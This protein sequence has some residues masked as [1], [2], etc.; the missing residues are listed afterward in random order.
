M[1]VYSSFFGS[2]PN[3]MALFFLTSTRFWGVVIN[4]ITF[5]FLFLVN[6]GYVCGSY[7]TL[8]QAIKM[9]KKTGFQYSVYESFPNKLVWS[10]T[11]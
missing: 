4:A 3:S 2:R 5:R 11:A 8:E 6:F 9:G 10:N 1:F 7:K